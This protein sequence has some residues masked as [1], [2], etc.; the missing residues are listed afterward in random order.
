MRAARLCSAVVENSSQSRATV[1]G[2]AFAFSFMTI[3]PAP[4][5]LSWARMDET[6]TVYQGSFS[7]E[8]ILS[9]PFKEA[10]SS[11]ASGLS[12]AV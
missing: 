2:E 1:S 5:P 3:P 10:D 12:S 9:K 6:F 8:N 11:R 4:R 7:A